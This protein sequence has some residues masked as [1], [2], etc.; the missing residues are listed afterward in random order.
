MTA[1]MSSQAADVANVPAFLS[2][3]WLLV[4]DKDTDNLIKWS[5][6]GNS[7][8]VIDQDL[9][10][11]EVLPRYFKHNN[12]PSFVR[13]LNMYGFRKKSH[14]EQGGLLLT[15]ERN[16][17]E[18]QHQHFVKGNEKGL[19]L[20]KRKTYNKEDLRFRSEGVEKILTDVKQMKTKQDGITGKLENMQRENE[21]L[22]REVMY[23]RKRHE[24]QQKI[25]S[26]LIQFLMT[27]AQQKKPIKRTQLPMIGGSSDSPS[28]PKYPKQAEEELF[29]E[30]LH[31]EEEDP[32][33]VIRGATLS[34]VE[35]LPI[36][37]AAISSHLPGE[38]AM[39]FDL[40]DVNESSVGPRVEVLSTPNPTPIVNS[41]G[42]GV[43]DYDSSMAS[44]DLAPDLFQDAPVT[45]VSNLGR[46]LMPRVQEQPP[47]STRPVLQRALSV[48]EQKQEIGEQMSGIASNLEYIQA[49]LSG[50]PNLNTD[51]LMEI[52]RTD[53][54]P[55]SSHNFLSNLV[56]S[57]GP[58]TLNNS[59]VKGTELVQY[60]PFESYSLPSTIFS[61]EDENSLLTSLDKDAQT[62]VTNNDTADDTSRK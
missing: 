60:Q 44:S 3:L 20:I 53:S 46:E 19:A 62:L 5:E 8:F 23:L 32:A 42:G 29:E 47:V 15:A 21:A 48:E 54:D 2:K 14:P 11:K 35:D 51:S 31:D 30:I 9:F 40:S 55:N 7:F 43:I 59:S 18:F 33:S 27:L 28:K 10:A 50:N 25:L 6:E 57:S 1:Q 39:T 12:M 13:Q 52:F 58:L 36:S 22:W 49:F 41:P 4:E 26:R 61:E 24:Q 56:D 34:E 17:I 38:S 45:E 16:K 37:P